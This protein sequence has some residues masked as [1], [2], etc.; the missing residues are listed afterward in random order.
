MDYS[1]SKHAKF[2]IA[3]H[4]IFVVKYRHPLLKKF[5][6]W[7]KNT[8]SVIAEKSSF[9]I[10]MMEVDIDH[11]HIM[12]LSSPNLSPTQIVRRLKQQSTYLIWQN[13]P[14][15]QKY[16]WKEKTFWSV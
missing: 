15:L 13:F 11:I 6:E 4:I 2:L 7:M 5:G 12:V 3:Y 9:S 16:F 10:S 8:F 1:C 14:E